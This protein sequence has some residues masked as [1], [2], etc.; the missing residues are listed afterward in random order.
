MAGSHGVFDVMSKRGLKGWETRHDVVLETLKLK[1]AYDDAVKS[2]H[3]A[4]AIAS[5]SPLFATIC[6]DV[7]SIRITH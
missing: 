7:G 3:N 4:G 2:L 1:N 6:S 5:A